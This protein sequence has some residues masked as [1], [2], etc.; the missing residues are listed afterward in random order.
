MTFLI[1]ASSKE[2]K[3]SI[4]LRRVAHPLGSWGVG[5]ILSTALARKTTFWLTQQ[6]ALSKRHLNT[7]IVVNQSGSVVESLPIR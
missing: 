1:I 7:D 2:I 4:P 6:T 5:R 3:V